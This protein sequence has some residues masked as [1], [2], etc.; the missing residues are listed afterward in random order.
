MHIYKAGL[1]GLLLI[2]YSTSWAQNI[3]ISTFEQ[4]TAQVDTAI[5]VMESIYERLGHKMSI[6]RFP[7]KRS[8]VEAN[9]GTVNGELIRI[10]AIEEQALNLIRIPYAIGSLKI[11][12]ITR[13]DQSKIQNI[14]GLNNKRVGIL[15]G[16]EFTDQITN[17]LDR[18]ALNS[19]EGL[20]EILL[21]SRVDVILFPELD[22]RHYIKLNDLEFRLNM[23][24]L[25]I[26]EVEL[27]HFIHKN[28]KAI[29]DQLT[30]KMKEMDQSGE[31]AA[32]V[33]SI[34]QA[35]K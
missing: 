3:R 29:A 6:I 31:L 5:K 24:E 19:I 35:Q 15:R 18:Q 12:A 26:V 20:F 34:E 16:V 7:A 32:L 33:E 1:V 9:L 25:P 11:V 22:A 14:K 30:A 27:F 21:S 28:D 4:K 23:S 17:N 2:V 8:L 10:K 13:A